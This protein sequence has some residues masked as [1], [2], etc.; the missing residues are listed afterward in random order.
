MVK[1]FERTAK[2]I[3]F[4]KT[5]IYVY[6]TMLLMTTVFG[7]SH[8]SDFVMSFV[9]NGFMWVIGFLIVEYTFCPRVGDDEEALPSRVMSSTTSS[10]KRNLS[11]VL[12]SLWFVSSL[13][14]SVTLSFLLVQ[15]IKGG[16]AFF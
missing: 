14:Y 13:I 15:Q 7:Y 2:I 4:A 11:V 8:L 1:L 16:G 3:Q 6:L 5:P 9:L 10:T 12:L